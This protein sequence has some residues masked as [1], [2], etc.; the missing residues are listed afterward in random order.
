M[1]TPPLILSLSKDPRRFD[2]LAKP[3]QA[4][5]QPAG[6]R[7]SPQDPF[8]LSVSKDGPGASL[9]ILQTSFDDEQAHQRVADLRAMAREDL[10]W[11]PFVLIAGYTLLAALAALSRGAYPL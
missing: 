1:T 8:V 11:G 5:S 3:G 4:P 6:A 10:R 7:P 2:P 9:L